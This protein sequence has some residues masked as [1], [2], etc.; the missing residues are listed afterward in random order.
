MGDIGY[1]FIPG[2]GQAFAL[3][4]VPDTGDRAVLPVQARQHGDVV[5]Q[6][7][8]ALVQLAGALPLLL[9]RSAKSVRYFLVRR[10]VFPAQQG[11]AGPVP[12]QNPAV[13]RHGQDAFAQALQDAEHVFLFLV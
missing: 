1:I 4:D 11:Q 12:L 2:A 6:H 3:G 5:L 13:L 8:F 7:R 10:G 9:E